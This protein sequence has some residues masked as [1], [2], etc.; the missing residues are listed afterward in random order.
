MDLEKEKGTCY[1]PPFDARLERTFSLSSKDFK[2]FFKSD[3]ARPN[4]R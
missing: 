2:Y 3:D 1:N 4:N